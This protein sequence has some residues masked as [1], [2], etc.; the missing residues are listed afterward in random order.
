MAKKYSF[1]KQA[2]NSTLK[3]I[4]LVILPAIL[5]SYF[6]INLNSNLVVSY[7]TKEN[8]SNVIMVLRILISFVINVVNEVIINQYMIPNGHYKIINKLR[9][10]MLFSTI[11]LCLI[12]VNKFG[13]IGAAFSNLFSE[14]IGFIIITNKLIKTIN[15][16]SNPQIF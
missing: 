3:K 5:V 16:K 1:D 11:M 12:L 13:L 4:F 14:S 2:G 8:I 10:T 15:N 7:F 9:I 6:V